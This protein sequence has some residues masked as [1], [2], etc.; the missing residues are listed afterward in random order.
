MSLVHSFAIQA[1]R[2]L[3]RSNSRR[4]L[5]AKTLHFQYFSKWDVFLPRA[6]RP[7]KA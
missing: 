3:S 6:W 4:G 5:H 7:F 2:Q 1:G